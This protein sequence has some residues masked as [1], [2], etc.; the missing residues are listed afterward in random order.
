MKTSCCE[1]FEGLPAK[2]RLIAAFTVLGLACG[3]I[4]HPLDTAYLVGETD[5]NPLEYRAGEKMTFT[6]A[7]VNADGPLEEGA[8][9]IDWRR[10]GDD[11]LVTNGTVAL[12]LARP[13]VVE[14]SLAQPG[15]VRLEAVVV[16]AKGEPFRKTFAPGALTADGSRPMHPWEREETRVFFD[17]GAGVGVDTLRGVPPPDD[18]AAFWKRQRAR[19]AEVPVKVRRRPLKS[20]N[21]T[22][23]LWAVEIDCAGKRPVTGYLSIPLDGTRKWPARLQTHG[24]SFFKHTPPD[25]IKGGEI[26]LDINAHGQRLEAFGGTD[27]ALKALGESIKSN[28]QRYA[29]DPKQNADPETAYFNGMALRVMRAL[30]CLKTLPEWNGRDLEASGTSQGGLQTIWAAALEP[31]LTRAQATVPWCCDMG[32]TEFGRNRG[33]WFVRWV[34]ALGYY[35]PINMARLIPS[36]C[37]LE[38]P[39]AGL[40]DY[41]C[42]PSGIAVFY[43]NLTCPREIG[44]MQGSTHSFVPSRARP[45]DAFRQ[46]AAPWR[47]LVVDDGGA[48]FR[49]TVMTPEKTPVS[50]V[51]DGRRRD[52]FAGCEVLARSLET[53]GIETRGRL[54]VRIDAT[55]VAEIEGA[56]RADFGETEY[57]LWFENDGKGPSKTLSDVVCCRYDFEKCSEEETCPRLRGIRGDHENCYCPYEIDC[58]NQPKGFRIEGKSRPTH[59]EFPYFNMFRRDGGLLCAIGWAGNWRA[60]FDNLRDCPRA[61]WRY[62]ISFR[63]C[64]EFASVLLPGERIRTARTVLLPHKGSDIDHVANLW[65]AWFRTYNEPKANAAGEALRPL[66]TAYFALDTGRPNSDGSVSEGADTWRPTLEKLVAEKVVPDF[67]WFDAGWYFDPRGRT[68]ASAWYDVGSWAL[69][70]VKWPDGSFRTSVD[71]GH[72]AGMKTLVWFEPERVCDP[73]ALAANYGYRTEWALPNGESPWRKGESAYWNNLGDPACWAWTRDRIFAMLDAGDVDLYR[74]DHNVSPDAA[75]REGDRRAESAL[76]LPRRGMT[77]TKGVMGHWAL[78]DAIVERG[79]CLGRCTYVDS[80]ASGGGRNDLESLRRGVPFTR[81]DQDRART[82]LRLSMNS[83]FCRWIPFHGSGSPSWEGGLGPDGTFGSAP[84][85]FR[86]ALLPIYNA[87]AEFSHNPKVNFDR[88]RRNLAEWRSVNDLLVKDFYVITSWHSGLDEGTWD[89]FAYDDAEKGESIVL[90]FRQAESPYPSCEARLKFA[91]PSAEYEITDADT[92]KTV[93]RGGRDLRERGY[94]IVLPERK[95]SALLRLKRVK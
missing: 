45:Q 42:P 51:Y 88:L 90:A 69:D 86:A 65:R 4:A 25:E 35:D 20:P 26:L 76:R 54:R 94:L 15:F 48:Y 2:R 63:A 95:S 93:R 70:T 55:L 56:Y 74:E 59:V 18:F 46:V 21:K 22:V 8:Y 50:F 41:I 87:C 1:P 44:W 14:T 9:R 11:G 73:A 40:G 78:W 85:D 53:T 36:T 43:N 23:A 61:D 19:L 58:W 62:R 34:P 5:R 30:D 60:D 39:R 80:C 67:R 10:T 68:I 12:P 91:D 82:A 84:Y 17:G 92:G 79:R 33:D 3:C 57:V 24:Y 37:R 6:L 27:E 38:I 47:A 89:V 52:G 32:G 13:L 28:G 75:W 66:T 29:F 64:P 81:S 71:A 77:E 31:A 7:L 16:D 49:G 83:S 72:A